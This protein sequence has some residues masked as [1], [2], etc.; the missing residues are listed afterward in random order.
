MSTDY[1]TGAPA[2]PERSP[3][4][5]TEHREEIESSP[6]LLTYKQ[7]G[8]LTGLP[9]GTL[10]DMVAKGAIPHV[11]LGPRL[12]RFPRAEVGQWLKDNMVRVRGKEVT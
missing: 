2:T 1:F 7:V 10:Y 6:L 5:V 12:V 11:R 9:A 4:S 3:H 8:Q